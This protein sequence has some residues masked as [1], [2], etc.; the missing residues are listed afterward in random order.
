MCARDEAGGDVGLPPPLLGGQ[1]ARR[2]RGPGDEVRVDEQV[3]FPAGVEVVEPRVH[4]ALAVDD[5]A[6]R[7]AGADV[8]GG[9]G[10]AL[11]QTDLPAPVVGQ[12]PVV[13]HQRVP[14]G[15]HA[16]Q[17]RGAHADADLGAVAIFVVVHARGERVGHGPAV[18][19][20]ELRPQAH[21][22]T[23]RVAPLVGPAEPPQRVLVEVGAAVE[24]AV[25]G[26]GLQVDAVGGDLRDA[27]G[28]REP[29]QISFGQ[30]GAQLRP[31]TWRATVLGVRLHPDEA[32]LQRDVPVGVERPG[33]RT[34]EDLVGEIAGGRAAGALHRASVRAIV[35]GQPGSSGR[36]GRAAERE[37]RQQQARAGE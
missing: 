21:A 2:A 11:G 12:P 10:A 4:L 32:V 22:L 30:A 31:R 26:Q 18:R 9:E 8:L 19:G 13:E 34:E 3:V 25:R 14:R 6:G 1:G 16:V 7:G 33:G 27:R 5:E 17:V 24:H 35:S 28:R 37:R 29:H 15:P 20:R 36:R 23:A